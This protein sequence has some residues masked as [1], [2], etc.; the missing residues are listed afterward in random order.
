MKQLE[1]SI[2]DRIH[3]ETSRPRQINGDD[4]HPIAF[5]MFPRRSMIHNDGDGLRKWVRLSPRRVLGCHVTMLL[6]ELPS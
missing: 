6:F 1:T 4:T 5:L 3:L 2:S